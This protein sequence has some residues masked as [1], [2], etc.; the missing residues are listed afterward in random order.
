MLTIKRQLRGEE[1]RQFEYVTVN[2]LSDNY[3][4][5]NT[6]LGEYGNKGYELVCVFTPTHRPYLKD[7]VTYFFKREKWGRVRSWIH[8]RKQQ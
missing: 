2:L 7:R 5:S 8:G 1:M 3:A 4:G 6:I